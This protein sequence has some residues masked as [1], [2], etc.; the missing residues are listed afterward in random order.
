ML[1][2]IQFPGKCLQA[3]GALAEFP[4]TIAQFGRQC[5]VRAAGVR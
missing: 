5:I 3:A 4:K 1:N 2:R